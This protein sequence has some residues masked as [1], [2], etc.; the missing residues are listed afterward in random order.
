MGVGGGS[1][2]IGHVLDSYILL[3]ITGDILLSGCC[4]DIVGGD[5]EFFVMLVIILTSLMV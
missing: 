3:G 5:I 4:V 2:G 1:N